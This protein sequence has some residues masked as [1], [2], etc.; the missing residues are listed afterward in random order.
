M[1]SIGLNQ[2]VRLT[3]ADGRKVTIDGQTVDDIMVSALEGG[4]SYWCE[5]VETVGEYLGEYASEQISRGGKLRFQAIDEDTPFTLALSSFTK[6][7]RKVI[8]EY[9][10]IVDE[11]GAV[12]AGNV[13][14]CIADSLVQYALFG[15]IVFA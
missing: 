6:G 11:D 1:K 15:E 4:I 5:S 2:K 7:L 13:D 8:S 10:D 14:G 9:P 12:N 3:T